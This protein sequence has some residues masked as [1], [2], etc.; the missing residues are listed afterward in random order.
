MW[1]WEKH[2]ILVSNVGSHFVTVIF[3]YTITHQLSQPDCMKLELSV[4]Y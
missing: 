3:T 4:T 1:A 2:F